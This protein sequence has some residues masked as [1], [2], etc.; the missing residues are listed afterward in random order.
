MVTRIQKWGNS[1]GLRF[2]RDVLRKASILIGDE[3]DVSVRNGEI[4]VKPALSIR[5][6][7]RLKDLVAGMPV[8]YKPIEENWGGQQGKE[9]W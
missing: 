2:P 6:K 9:V 4:V 7:Y 3:V 8:R 1:Q 5:R